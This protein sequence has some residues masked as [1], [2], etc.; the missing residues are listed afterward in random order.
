[1]ALVQVQQFETG[2]R[3]GLK[4]LHQCGKRVKTKSQKV[5]GANCYVFRSYKRE[6]GR[7]PLMKRIKVDIQCN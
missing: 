3:Y 7:G 5:L 4:I 2:T 1:M 6:N